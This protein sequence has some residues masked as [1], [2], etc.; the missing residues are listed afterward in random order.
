MTLRRAILLII[1]YL[2]CGSMANVCVAWGLA[3]FVRLEAPSEHV[4]SHLYWAPP[5]PNQSWLVRETNG[6][7][8]TAIAAIRAGRIWER[9]RRWQEIPEWMPMQEVADWQTRGVVIEGRGWPRPS[10]YCWITSDGLGGGWTT[11]PAPDHSWRWPSSLF[12]ANPGGR[13]RPCYPLTPIWPNTIWNTVFYATILLAGHQ[14]SALGRRTLRRRR[15]FCPHC[16]YDLRGSGPAVGCPECG[17]G[18]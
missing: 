18:R 13:E 7:G 15:G 4:S 10:L 3:H 2:L 6:P 8:S 5:P 11:D 12:A 14:V 9:V 16:K 17:R 1:A